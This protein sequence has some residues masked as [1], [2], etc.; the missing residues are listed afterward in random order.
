MKAMTKRGGSSKRNA[1]ASTHACTLGHH[2]LLIV[3]KVPDIKYTVNWP[4][5]S[6]PTQPSIVVSVKKACPPDS[7]ASQRSPQGAESVRQHRDKEKTRQEKQKN[8]SS[9]AQPNSFKCFCKR[10]AHS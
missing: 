6:Q 1:C 4:Q 3:Q 2:S 7:V 8:Q 10:I 5:F 9:R